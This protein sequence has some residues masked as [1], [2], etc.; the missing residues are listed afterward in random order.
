MTSLHLHLSAD[1]IMK[2]YSPSVWHR[3]PKGREFTAK[4]IHACAKKLKVEN[5]GDLISAN[6]RLMALKK[7]MI[8]YERAVTEF[9]SEEI[10][11]DTSLSQ[12]L[13]AIAPSDR[14]GDVGQAM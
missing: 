2:R 4:Q 1:Q 11:K 6:T 8:K 14:T 3:R 12:T 10:P 9:I 7:F 13:F 5:S